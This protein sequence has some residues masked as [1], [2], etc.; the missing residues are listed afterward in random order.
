M[1]LGLLLS[2]C[3]SPCGSNKD[4]LI[5]NYNAFIKKTQDA[6]LSV[7]AAEWN[8]P[9]KKFRQFVKECYPKHEAKMS[10][11]EKGEFWYNAAGYIYAR[12]GKS[13]FTDLAASNELVELVKSKIGGMG[14]DLNDVFNDIQSAWGGLEKVFNGLK[15][16][17]N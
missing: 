17:V 15:D 4:E 10:T 1:S 5:S 16:L 7:N 9:D 8:E 12:Y 2:S 6:K 3:S 11:I 13:A 14:K